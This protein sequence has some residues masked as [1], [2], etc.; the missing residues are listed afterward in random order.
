MCAVLSAVDFLPCCIR[1]LYY[2][3]SCYRQVP[4]IR[5]SKLPGSRERVRLALYADDTNSFIGNV[6]EI[7]A[8]LEWFQV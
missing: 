8:T 2:R 3:T 1:T 6:G 5:G 4:R 7:D